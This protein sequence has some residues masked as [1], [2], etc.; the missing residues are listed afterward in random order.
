MFNVMAC[1][2]PSGPKFAVV[3]HGMP[4]GAVGEL[5]L[6]LSIGENGC[7]KKAQKQLE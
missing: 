6:C 1:H 4:Y 3:F 5:E 7:K 2:G